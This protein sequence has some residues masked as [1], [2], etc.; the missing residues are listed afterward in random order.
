[1]IDSFN[2]LLENTT[3]S[4]LTLVLLHLDLSLFVV[5]KI[6]SMTRVKEKNFQPCIELTVSPMLHQL[7]LFL[8]N[9]SKQCGPRDQGAWVHTVCMKEKN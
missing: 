3:G 2:P 7:L 6:F 9:Y 1:M 8:E 5:N 4:F